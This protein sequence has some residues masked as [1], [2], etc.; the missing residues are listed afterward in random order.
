[1][2]DNTRSEV[3]R[4][5]KDNT[6]FA[7]QLA[8]KFKSQIPAEDRIQASLLGMVQ[9]AYKF[10]HERGYKFI[11]YANWYCRKELILLYQKNSYVYIPPKPYASGVRAPPSDNLD[12]YVYDADQKK[13]SD[14]LVDQRPLQDSTEPW[15]ET[16]IQKHLNAKEQMVIL[17][18][19]GLYNRIPWT[20][21][22]LA[23]YFGCSRARIYKIQQMALGKLRRVA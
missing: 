20:F 3:E 4:L 1:M 8:L 16:L 22:K 19:F 15:L 10:D 2:K 18:R 13:K 5:V 6:G 23:T 21:D 7:C 17:H 11:T 12:E 9:A 14:N